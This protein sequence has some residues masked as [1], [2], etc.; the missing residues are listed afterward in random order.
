MN[1]LAIRIK[2]KE[3]TAAASNKSSDAEIYAVVA[4]VS[5]L[6][7]LKIRVIGNSL[8]IS[9]EIRININKREFLKKGI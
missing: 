6:K 8:I 4:N 7:G 1:K 9:R 2:N 5:K 3:G